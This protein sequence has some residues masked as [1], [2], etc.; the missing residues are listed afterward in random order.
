M[1]LPVVV[2][3]LVLD[4]LAGG[5]LSE[6]ASAA[7]RRVSG[8]VNNTAAANRAPGNASFSSTERQTTS[9]ISES[10][11]TA[12]TESSPYRGTLALIAAMS[13]DKYMTWTS[14]RS[15]LSKGTNKLPAVSFNTTSAAGSMFFAALNAR[16]T[17]PR[18][19]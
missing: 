4:A 13:P 9:D 5:L 3:M 8:T 18:P 14:R 12:A 10:P 19:R 6:R 2:L 16:Y 15:N 11:T 17:A 7:L 1:R